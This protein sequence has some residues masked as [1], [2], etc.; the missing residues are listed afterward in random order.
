MHP[1]RVVREVT[2][3]SQAAFG[4][5]VGCTAET[6][7]KMENGKLEIGESMH[8][9][10][11][12]ATGVLTVKSK[13]DKPLD[14]AGEPFTQTTYAEWRE[15]LRGTESQNSKFWLKEMQSRL[16]VI[17]EAAS[18]PSVEKVQML[19]ANLEEWL[20]KTAE[21]LSLKASIEK[22]LEERKEE[23]SKILSYGEWRKNKVLAILWG[24][25]DDK[26]KKN[27]EMLKLKRDR[28][29]SWWPSSKTE[30]GYIVI[31]GAPV[32]WSG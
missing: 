4:R 22:V 5:M 23:E 16:D 32:P 25:M 28:R 8:E 12:M 11:R 9:R 20:C 27:G 3:L 24:F 13:T 7:E 15:Y 26:E 2:K 19:Y 10:I 14:Y 1:L 17:F 21:K 30:P 31:P 29:V 6:I 18:R